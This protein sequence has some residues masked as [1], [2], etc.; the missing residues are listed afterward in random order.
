MA[1][2]P[3]FE[4]RITR[5]ALPDRSIFRSD[6]ER[7]PPVFVVQVDTLPRD[8]DVEWHSVGLDVPESAIATSGVAVVPGEDAGRIGVLSVRA[9]KTAFWHATITRDGRRQFF[10]RLREVVAA[11]EAVGVQCTYATLYA[12][13]LVTKEDLEACVGCL[14]VM[15]VPCQRVIHSGGM[16]AGAI[17][18]RVRAEAWSEDVERVLGMHD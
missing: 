9:G 4:D 7:A 2:A 15:V 11:W 18:G 13:P 8:A 6:A 14:P 10:E 17:V 5:P 16:I 1:S 3:A 12:S